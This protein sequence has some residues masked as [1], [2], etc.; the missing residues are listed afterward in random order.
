MD[1]IAHPR[2]IRRRVVRSVYV[3][4]GPTPHGDLQHVGQQ[5]VGDAVGVFTDQAGLMS[6]DRVEVAQQGDR[7]ARVGLGQPLEHVLGHQLGLAIGIRRQTGRAVLGDRHPRGIAID[8][9]RRAE[10]QLEDAGLGHRLAQRDAAA[11]IGLVIAQ[12][13]AHAFADGLEPGEVQHRSYRIGG[14]ERIEQRAIA[15]VALDELGLATGEGF[16]PIQRDLGTVTKI[17]QHQYFVA[18]QEQ[19]QHGVRPDVTRSTSYQNH[20]YTS[21]TEFIRRARGIRGWPYERGR[22]MHLQ[23]WVR[24]KTG[25]AAAQSRGPMPG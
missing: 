25:G 17:V 11:D 24:Q 14:E 19:L 8:G 9:R 13:L 12:W 16:D 10:H 2:A 21:H 22:C 15:H 3:Q 20:V 6:A 23:G 5:V 18:R 4:L 7:P 1:V